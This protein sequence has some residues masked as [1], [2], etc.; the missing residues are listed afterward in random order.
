MARK[1]RWLAVALAALACGGCKQLQEFY[2]EHVTVFDIQPRMYEL[3]VTTFEASSLAAPKAIRGLYH[4]AAVD[5]RIVLIGGVD[6]QNFLVDSVEVFDPAADTWTTG[7]VWPTV[8][9]A[10]DRAVT[11]DGRMCLSGGVTSITDDT[12]VPV[13]DCYDVTTNAWSTLPP[14]PNGVSAAGFGYHAGSFYALG[15]KDAAGDV[16]SAYSLVDGAASWEPLADVPMPCHA[17]LEKTAG[18]K[19]F[20]PRCATNEDALLAYDIAT[21]TWSTAPPPPDDP[22]RGTLFAVHGDDLLFLDNTP[23]R[24]LR[25]DTVNEIW[26]AVTEPGLDSAQI[27]SSVVVG[28]MAYLV[29]MSRQSGSIWEAAFEVWSYDFTTDT[30]DHLVDNPSTPWEGIWLTNI[31]GRFL[32]PA[33]VMEPVVT[34][35]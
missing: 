22:D 35:Q 32:A 18:G 28:D 15:G 4:A 13:L 29:I 20:L 3:D 2:E 8:R 23:P 30:W 34:V 9:G 5:D 7:A 16:A 11:D 14:L 24:S 6:N 1:T 17:G 10:R 19:I 31:G 33:V 12:E 25:Y 27:G 21:D 26:T